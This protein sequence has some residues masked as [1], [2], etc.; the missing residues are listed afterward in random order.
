MV[1]LI[2]FYGIKEANNQ[3]FLTLTIE[4]IFCRGIVDSQ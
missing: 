3:R 4:E 1:P 2:R